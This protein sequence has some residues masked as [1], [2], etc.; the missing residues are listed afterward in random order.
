[1]LVIKK[2]NK[3][4]QD[5]NNANDNRIGILIRIIIRIM[6]IMI[7]KSITPIKITVLMIFFS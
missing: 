4:I 3:K 7:L 5:I 1:M 2:Y 6:T